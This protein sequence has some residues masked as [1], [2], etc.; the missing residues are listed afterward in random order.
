MSRHGR[1]KEIVTDKLKSY[2]AALKVL[3][4]EK[5]QNTDQYKNNQIENSHLHFR[6]REKMWN[7]FRS[8][9]SLQKFI[10]IHSSF[11]NLFNHQRHIENRQTFKK[12]RQRSVDIWQNICVS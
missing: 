4:L 6:R 12:L 1:P 8:I 10:S 11:F 5:L 9:R 3:G 7:K 2:R